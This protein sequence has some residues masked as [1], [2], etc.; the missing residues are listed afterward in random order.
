MEKANNYRYFPD[1]YEVEAKMKTTSF[2]IPNTPENYEE[3]NKLVDASGGVY[4][5]LRVDSRYD[6]TP[7]EKQTPC[8]VVDDSMFIQEQEIE[9]QW[10]KVK[11]SLKILRNLYTERADEEFLS[12]AK[13]L[14]EGMK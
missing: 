13:M 10:T 8:S 7:E 3:I 9:T 4:R 2:P 1:P 12:R 5:G 6:S 14:V 11:T